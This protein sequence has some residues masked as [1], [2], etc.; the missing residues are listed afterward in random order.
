V[1]KFLFGSV[2]LLSIAIPFLTIYCTR[3][4][5]TYLLGQSYAIE[6]FKFASVE[7]NFHFA[8]IT[9]LS[10]TCRTSTSSPISAPLHT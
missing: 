4:L 9:T 2:G 10:G 1:G 6:N 3:A 7:N 5:P 8:V